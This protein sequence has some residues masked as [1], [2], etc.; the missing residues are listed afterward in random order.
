MVYDIYI[1]IY[2]YIY[3]YIYIYI[4]PHGSYSSWKN[5]LT[6]K[7]SNLK[8]LFVAVPQFYI[9]RVSQVYLDQYS[10]DCFFLN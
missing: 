1:Y 6:K 9:Q 5:S 2:L 3:I 10:K 8:T 4:K 7:L